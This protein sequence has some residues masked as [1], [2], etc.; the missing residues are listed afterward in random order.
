M[1][2]GSRAEENIVRWRGGEGRRFERIVPHVQL[3]S[4]HVNGGTETY[5]GGAAGRMV[6][7]RVDKQYAAIVH[8]T[9][10]RLR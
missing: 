6:V 7:V 5:T 9:R 1:I 10:R 4:G 3:G 2:D 8:L